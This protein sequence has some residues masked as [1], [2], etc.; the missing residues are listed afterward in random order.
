M[1]YKYRCL[2]FTC[3]T[4]RRSLRQ[5]DETLWKLREIVKQL[6]ADDCLLFWFYYYFFKLCHI[7]PSFKIQYEECD[8]SWFES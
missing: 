4:L 8:L 6:F 7:R 5:F 3:K 1:A 2:V